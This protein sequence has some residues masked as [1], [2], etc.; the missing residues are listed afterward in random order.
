M[1]AISQDRATNA[2]A[3]NAPRIEP[4]GVGP[5]VSALEEVA[6]D[7]TLPRN[8]R[9][10][11]QS[12]KAELERA[13]VAEDVRIASA[14]DRID[15]LANDSNLPVHGRTALWSIISQLESLS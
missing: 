3:P 9:K 5:I 14:I 13:G 1:S 11:A 10:G 7:L 4:A 2:P 15:E 8:V 6:E 12:A